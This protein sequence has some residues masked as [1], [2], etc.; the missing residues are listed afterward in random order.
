MKTSFLYHAFGIREQECSRVRYE[1]KRII[2]EVQTRSE[3]LRCSCCQSRNIIRSGTIVREIKSIPIGKT[4]IIIRMKVQ[5]LECKSCQSIRQENIHF[6]TGK[7]SYSNK[8]ARYVV[9]LSR[10]GT[11]KD[12]AN[13]LH[14]SWDTV[15]EIQ[16]KY[17][18]RQYNN[19]DFK[20][21]RYIGIDGFAVAKGHIYKTIVADL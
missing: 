2:L 19:P 10:I 18:Y 13:L 1:D 20:G 9:D 7:H 5:R 14:L 21:V 8:M 12:V 16:K 15:K 6:V 11:I 4:P 3:K 17:L